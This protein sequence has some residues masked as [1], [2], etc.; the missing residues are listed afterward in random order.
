MC[1]VNVSEA[2]ISKLDKAIAKLYNTWDSD[3]AVD[4]L[5]PGGASARV[6]VD[7]VLTRSAVLAGI[8]L[9]LVDVDLAT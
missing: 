8:G 4:A 9:A 7:A 5:K 1:T 6:L 3:L 2:P